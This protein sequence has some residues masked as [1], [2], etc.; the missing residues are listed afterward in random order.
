MYL[1]RCSAASVPPLP[2][3]RSASLSTKR[4]SRAVLNLQTGQGA[5]GTSRACTVMPPGAQGKRSTPHP[6]QMRISRLP[7]KPRPKFGGMLLH[8]LTLLSTQHIRQPPCLTYTYRPLGLDPVFLH[9][10]R[11]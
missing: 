9:S 6:P 4:F 1:M 3:Q 7:G 10:V 2:T 8:P 11:F 5:R